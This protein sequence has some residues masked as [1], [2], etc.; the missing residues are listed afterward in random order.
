MRE[1]HSNNTKQFEN[2]CREHGLRITPQR[3][4]IYKELASS[5]EHPSVESLYEA[6]RK[7]LPNISFDTV[8]RTAMSFAEIG[9]VKVVEGWG[10][11]KRFDPNIR[12]HHHFRCLK[13]RKIIDFDF[14]PF[15]KLEIPKTLKDKCQIK[16]KRVVIEGICEQ[17]R[18][19]KKRKNNKRA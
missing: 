4:I 3:V 12:P 5:K 16:H 11:P 2:L 1:T 6:V 19:K 7:I 15:D 14:E 9:L 13:C 8:Y 18:N 10:E 17:C